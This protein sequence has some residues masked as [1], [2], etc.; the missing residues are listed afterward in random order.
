M[1]YCMRLFLVLATIAGLLPRTT[2]A[3]AS[4]VPVPARLIDMH[5]HVWERVPTSQS[6]RDSL[7]AAFDTFHLQRAVASGSAPAVLDLITL[8]PNRLL[9]GLSYG[10]DLPLPQLATLRASFSDKRLAVFGEID[11]AWLGESVT[12]AQ[13]AP[14]F[15][16][17]QAMN[18]PVA[19]FTGVAPAGTQ[20]DPCCPHYRTSLGRPARV[21]ELLVRYPKLRVY[22]MQAGWPFR[23]ETIALMHT[24]PN[25]YAD[26]GNVAGNPDIPRA[27][28]YD[29]LHALIRAG[30]GKRIMFGSGLSAQEWAAKIGPI[31]A[32]IQEAPFL[33]DEERADIFYNNADRFLR[34]TASLHSH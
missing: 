22:L 11:A 15:D 32:E 23:D 5:F 18:I 4:A 1:R 2:A 13:L 6:F 31:I 16:L 17:S 12:S 34:G 19:I 14:Y 21:E 26:L 30:L 3:Q 9:G 8:A 24:Y 27:E 7:I 29:Y 33:S 25:V 20:L 28:F 10:P